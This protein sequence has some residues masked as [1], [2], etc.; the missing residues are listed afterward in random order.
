MRRNITGR[1][2]A[3]AERTCCKR[4]RVNVFTLI[5]LLVVIAIIAILASLLLPALSKARSYAK[6]IICM[7]NNKQFGLCFNMYLDDY[8]RWYP[9]RPVSATANRCWDYQIADYLNCRPA[10]SAAIFHCPEGGNSVGYQPRGYFMNNY[11]ATNEYGNNGR[12]GKT[13]KGINALKEQMQVLLIDTW[14]DNQDKSEWLLWGSYNNYEYIS[15]DIN[16]KYIAYRH[17]RRAI[18]LQKDGSVCS[19]FRGISGDGQGTLWIFYADTN[20]WA[21]YM[22]GQNV[23]IDR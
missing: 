1:F 10:A 18:Y 21:Y 16:A 15:F 9:Q 6:E 14:Q 4:L 11:I 19:T 22:N 8:D 20:H 5:E 12:A 3:E 13:G 17:T 2:D 23:H 7:N